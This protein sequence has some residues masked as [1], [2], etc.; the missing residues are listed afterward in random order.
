VSVR[1]ACSVAVLAFCSAFSPFGASA[2][3]SD[4]TRAANR[5]S[6]DHL[7]A[8]QTFVRAAMTDGK[9]CAPEERTASAPMMQILEGEVRLKLEQGKKGAVLRELFAD[10]RRVRECESRCR[11]GV[12]LAWLERAEISEWTTDLRTR[13]ER[14]DSKKTARCAEANRKWIC[15]SALW[16][17]LVDEARAAVESGS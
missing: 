7:A 11:C 13:A 3:E 10:G 16:R 15:K 1:G 12:Y 9:F 6:V 17:G 4:F 8:V 2:G 5:A 14:L